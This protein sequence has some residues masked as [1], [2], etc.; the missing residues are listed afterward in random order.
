M[1]IVSRTPSLGMQ[2][3]RVTWRS[4]EQQWHPMAF[5]LNHKLKFLMQKYGEVEVLHFSRLI[6][7]PE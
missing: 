2:S 7:E 1:S 6:C 5:L 4:V 3:A